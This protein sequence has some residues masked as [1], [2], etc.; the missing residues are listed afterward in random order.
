MQR[1]DLIFK[2]GCIMKLHFSESGKRTS[3]DETGKRSVHCESSS[4]SRRKQMSEAIN[5]DRRRFLRT[6]GMTIAAC[7]FGA[8]GF[9]EGSIFSEPLPSL[10]GATGWLNSE[11]LKKADLH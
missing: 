9:A 1:V 10:D 8:A 7:Q 4:C 11:P 6:A 5:H 3:Y 2:C